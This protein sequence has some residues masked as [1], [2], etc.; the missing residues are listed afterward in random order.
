M[1][2]ELSILSF[3]ST[4]KSRAAKFWLEINVVFFY[5]KW[6]KLNLFLVF[7]RL[8]YSQ[9]GEKLKDI[10]LLFTCFFQTLAI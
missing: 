2:L 4:V 8:I 9:K 1:K 5:F 10:Y 6:N 7:P 3:Y